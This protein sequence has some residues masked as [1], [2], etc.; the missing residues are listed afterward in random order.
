MLVIG[1]TL[2]FDFLNQ[3]EWIILCTIK[4]KFIYFRYG[5]LKRGGSLHGSYHD[6]LN[7]GMDRYGSLK[8]GKITPTMLEDTT[9]YI[10]PISSRT[11][12]GSL[13]HDLQQHSNELAALRQLQIHQQQMQYE[14]TI[15]E[16]E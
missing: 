13:S 5:S 15:A 14:Q 12:S 6:N 7:T 16:T 4:K 3:V 8:R 9:D 1:K 10:M 2:S 11:L